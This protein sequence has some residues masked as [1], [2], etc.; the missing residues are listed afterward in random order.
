[1]KTNVVVAA[2]V[3]LIFAAT[4][5]TAATPK[6]DLDAAIDKLPAS[7][8]RKDQLHE[9]KEFVATPLFEAAKEKVKEYEA[10]HKQEVN[11]LR[12][13]FAKLRGQYEE[14]I[15][16]KVAEIKAKNPKAYL[17]NKQEEVLKSIKTNLGI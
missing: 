8:E 13:E 6:I 3:L 10:T 1:M 7:D 11:S 15:R 5:I 16:A 4:F 2:L 17:M 14:K 9:L 12:Q